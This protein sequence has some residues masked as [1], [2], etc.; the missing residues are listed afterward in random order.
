MVSSLDLG[1]KDKVAIVAGGGAAGEGICNW[2]AASILLAEAG[3]IVMVV[4]RD[5][6]LATRTVEMICER[7]G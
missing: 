7:G 4:D 6:A 1:L 3:A 5:E 2:R